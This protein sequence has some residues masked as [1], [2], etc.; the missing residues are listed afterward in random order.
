MKVVTHVATL[1]ALALV[2]WLMPSILIAGFDANLVWIK[3]VWGW[4]YPYLP[5]EASIPLQSVDQIYGSLVMLVQNVTKLLP[6]VTAR[7]IE[8]A[9][10]AALGEGWI[11][12]AEVSLCLRAIWIVRWRLRHRATPLV[13]FP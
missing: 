2:W 7:Q 9:T 4:I 11:L 8:A 10:R 3:W 1:L 13:A 12:V 6:E 5:L